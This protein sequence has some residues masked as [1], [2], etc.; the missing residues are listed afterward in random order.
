[1]G[2][3]QEWPR[4]ELK[5]IQRRTVES[6]SHYVLGARQMEEITGKLGQVG[7]AASAAW[8]TKAE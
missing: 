6:I 2:G 3:N 5:Q 1:M 4:R 8:R 7:Q